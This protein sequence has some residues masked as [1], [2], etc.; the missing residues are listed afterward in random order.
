MDQVVQE[1]IGNGRFPIKFMPG[2]DGALADDEGGA[3]LVTIVND[4]LE[5]PP[6][7][8]GEGSETPVIDNEEVSLAVGQEFGIRTVAFGDLEVLEKF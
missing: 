7:G 2:R 8:R 4:F 1:S 5:V 6:F 3:A